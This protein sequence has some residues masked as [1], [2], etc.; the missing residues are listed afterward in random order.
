MLLKKLYGDKNQ[1]TMGVPEDLSLRVLRHILFLNLLPIQYP[2]C[3]SSI[4]LGSMM[5]QVPIHMIT[6]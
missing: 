5:I 1:A 4:G 6:Y 2:L 3:P